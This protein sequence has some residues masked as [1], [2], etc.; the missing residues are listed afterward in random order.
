MSKHSR[1]VKL[2]GKY[3][4]FSPHL[5]GGLEI[6]FVM[7]FLQVEKQFLFCLNQAW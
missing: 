5:L 7:K 6:Y 2:R 3:R 4:G 1:V